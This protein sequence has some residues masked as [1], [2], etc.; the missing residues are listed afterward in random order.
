ME[1]SSKKGTIGKII[2]DN[3]NN[4][5]A[6][7]SKAELVTLMESLLADS[8]NKDKD[9]FLAMVKGKKDLSSAMTV[10][11]NYMFAGDGLRA[12]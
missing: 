6:A 7:K 8:T 9:R 1:L 10:C 11:Y 5:N 3:L 2:K 12:L 4:I